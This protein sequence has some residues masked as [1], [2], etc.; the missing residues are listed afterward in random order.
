M[1][2]IHFLY[3]SLLALSALSLAGGC[4]K[5]DVKD[6]S[7]IVKD[8]FKPTGDDIASI[9]AP[10]Y[11]VMRPMWADWYGNFDLQDKRLV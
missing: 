2:Q 1:K 11:I 9:I 7:E 6:Y 3:K 10:V 4:T 8:N 5:L